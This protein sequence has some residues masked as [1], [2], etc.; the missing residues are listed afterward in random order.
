LTRIVIVKEEAR[1]RRTPILEHAHELPTREVRRGTTK[2]TRLEENIGAAAIRLT[3]DD[4][5]EIET[6]AAQIT[7]Q[8][9][10]YSEPLE[11]RRGL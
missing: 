7:I 8:G 3:G 9:A 6:A 10:R 11:K 2:L 1:E 4:L 5:R